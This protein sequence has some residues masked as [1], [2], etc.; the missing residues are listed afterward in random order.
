MLLN[1]RNKWSILFSHLCYYNLLSV[2]L[3]YNSEAAVSVE[4]SIT[5]LLSR[6][7][8]I[9]LFLQKLHW[10]L[11]FCWLEFKVAVI[12][13]KALHNL[14]WYLKDMYLSKFWGPSLASQG[15]EDCCARRAF[16]CHGSQLNNLISRHWYLPFSVRWQCLLLS[17]WRY[18]VHI[19]T[20]PVII[21]FKITSLYNN[22]PFRKV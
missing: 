16:L 11:L 1:A 2:G 20:M 22:P 8:H 3:S 12:L 9:I 21:F 5:R 6:R 7:G 13:I 15:C 14:D 4:C 17:H 18:S 19:Q 10:V